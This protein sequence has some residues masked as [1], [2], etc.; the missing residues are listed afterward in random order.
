MR[1]LEWREEAFV[2]VIR[3]LVLAGILASAAG[4]IVAQDGNPP[5]ILVGLGP[6]G[7]LI[8]L[9]HERH[10][11][12]FQAWAITVEEPHEIKARAETFVEPGQTRK[13]ESRGKDWK[14]EGTVTL[15]ESGRLTYRLT[16]FHAGE[17]VTSASASLVSKDED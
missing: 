13:L 17:R 10:V 16:L 4:V 1:R 9:G 5:E 8:P 6:A 11:F 2:R 14:L 7:D 3:C 15:A 12:T